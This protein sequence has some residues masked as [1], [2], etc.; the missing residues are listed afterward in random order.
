VVLAYLPY[1]QRYDNRRCSGETVSIRLNA[2]LQ[3]LEVIENGS[4]SSPTSALAFQRLVIQCPNLDKL[5]LDGND[6][7][8]LPI[9]TWRA[10]MT[11]ISQLS[12]TSCYSELNVLRAFP[13]DLSGQLTIKCKG[14]ISEI[15]L[16]TKSRVVRTG[17]Y[18]SYF[19]HENPTMEEVTAA[20]FHGRLLP[21]TISFSVSEREIYEDVSALFLAICPLSL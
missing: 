7:Y 3:A 19:A 4:E 14:K 20:L 15:R 5:I 1:H 13:P 11:S 9:E 21:K 6:L 10:L 16:C 17:F 2:N 12:A 8:S 18:R